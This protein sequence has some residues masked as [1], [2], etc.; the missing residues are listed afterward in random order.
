M[1]DLRVVKEFPEVFPEDIIDLPPERKVEFF[2]DLVS[3]TRPLSMEP[4]RMSPT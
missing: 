4:Y 3:G 2:I 1:V